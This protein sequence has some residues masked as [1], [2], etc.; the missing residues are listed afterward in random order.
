MTTSLWVLAANGSRARLL[1]TRDDGELHERSAWYNAEGRHP[2]PAADRLPRTS[3]SASPARHAIE[4]RLSARARAQSR[5]AREL[6]EVLEQARAAGLYDRLVLA[7]PAR[8]LGTMHAALPASVRARVAFEIG[9]NV[10]PESVPKLRARLPDALFAAP[11]RI[12]A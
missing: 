8:F 5:F 10:V 2:A 6:A 12:V 4:P 1:E 3:E 9:H 11:R 7:A